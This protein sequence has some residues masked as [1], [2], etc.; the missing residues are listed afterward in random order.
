MTQQHSAFDERQLLAAALYSLE[1]LTARLNAGEPIPNALLGDAVDG[2]D[3]V[4]GGRRHSAREAFVG[5]LSGAE[6]ATARV[7]LEEMLWALESHERG[8]V[9]AAGAFVIRARACIRL[10]REH[11]PAPAPSSSAH[12]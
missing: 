8:E 4:I 7:L 11:A 9:G 2:L 10:L 1:N 6:R 3:A 12:G 5:V